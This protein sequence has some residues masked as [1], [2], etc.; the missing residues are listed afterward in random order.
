[1]ISTNVDVHR[2]GHKAFN[3]RDFDAMVKDYAANISWTDRA[4]S[5]TFETPQEFKNVFLAGWVQSSTDIQIKD[6]HYVDAGQTV[7]CTFSVVGTHDGPL[8]PFPATHKE[9]CLPLCEMWHF[10]FSGRVGGG[11]L[12]YDQVSLL[13][14]LGLMP[15]A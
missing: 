1:M 3:N 9:F 4:R 5:L 12:Y 2:A 13:S 11:D 7:L 8:G 15:S 6:P 10:D 14:Q